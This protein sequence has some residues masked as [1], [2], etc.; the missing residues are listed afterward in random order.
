MLLCKKCDL[1]NFAPWCQFS[2]KQEVVVEVLG[3]KAMKSGT[4]PQ[5]KVLYSEK[6]QKQ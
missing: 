1:F 5:V 4:R 3:N 6:F 2:M